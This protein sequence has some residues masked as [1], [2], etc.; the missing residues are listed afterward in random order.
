MKEKSKSTT[1]NIDITRT[2]QENGTVNKSTQFTAH[3]MCFTFL[4]LKGKQPI[5]TQPFNVQSWTGY[6]FIHNNHMITSTPSAIIITI[7][8]DLGAGTIDDLNL[9]YTEAAQEHA[10]NFAEQHD[11]MLGDILQCAKPHFT[12]TK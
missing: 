3:N 8:E 9:K 5:S 11:L 12:I 6:R 1:G 7:N 4:L 10:H 2:N